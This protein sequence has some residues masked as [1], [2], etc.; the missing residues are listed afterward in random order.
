MATVKDYRW[1]PDKLQPT[2]DAWQG[3]FLLVIEEIK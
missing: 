3:T 2:A 1:Q